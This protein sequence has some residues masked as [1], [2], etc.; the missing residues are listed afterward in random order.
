MSEAFARAMSS[1]PAEMAYATVEL[2]R[3]VHD[4]VSL[5]NLLNRAVHVARRC[6]PGVD[7]CSVTARFRDAPFTAAT[8]GPRAQD[9]DEHQ[10]RLDDGPCLGAMRSTETVTMSV[11]ELI[12]TWPGLAEPAATNEIRTC[13]SVPL[14]DPTGAGPE[15]LGSIN[16]YSGSDGAFGAES[17]DFIR[18]LVEYISRGMDDYAAVH[19]AE[20]QAGQ[21]KQA[22]ISR[23]PIEQAK[24]ILMAVHQVGAEEAFEMLR[25]QSQHTNVKLNQVAAA[26]VAAQSAQPTTP[27]GDQPALSGVQAEFQSAFDQAPIGMAIAD[28]DGTMRSVNPALARLLGADAECLRGANLM[29]LA[30]GDD[31]PVLQLRCAELHSG[32]VRMVTMSIRLCS[33]N[34]DVLHAKVSASSALSQAGD[35]SHLV[36][37]IQAAD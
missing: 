15:A 18:V 17:L 6:V 7:W 11:T 25:T 3:P 19:S 23:A 22:M 16:L 10:Y 36:L 28:P 14:L 34:G 27:V 8:T 4:D 12:E 37:H 20:E 21:L 26:F 1:H 30:H 2:H 29:Q 24:G 35:I 32:A 9:M 13:L 33:R 5:V 31:L